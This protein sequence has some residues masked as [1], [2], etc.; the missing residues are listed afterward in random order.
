MP[1]ARFNIWKDGR[2]AGLFYTS[3]NEEVSVAD[4]MQICKFLRISSGSAF[5]SVSHE[6]I[7]SLQL[8]K[9]PR[10]TN[11]EGRRYWL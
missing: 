11:E 5:F 2:L 3:S 10:Y 9:K 6:A 4:K 1:N 8:P 7:D